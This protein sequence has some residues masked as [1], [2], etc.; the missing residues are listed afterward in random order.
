MVL[1]HAV[2]LALP[3]AVFVAAGTSRPL[4]QG[5]APAFRT[6]VDVVQLDVSVLDNNRQPIRGL[7]AADFT[8]TERGEARPIVSFEAI[9][10]P[11]TPAD[12][13]R[14]VT[15]V[16]PDVTVNHQVTRRVVVLFFDDFHTPFDPGVTRRAKTIGDAVLDRLGAADLAAVVYAVNRSNGQD[17][18]SDRALLREA[19]SR[20]L[21]TGMGVAPSTHAFSAAT[22]PTA[23]GVSGA[24][25]RASCVQKAMEQTARLLG[26]APG[27]RKTFLF[28]SSFTPLWSDD[29]ERVGDLSDWQGALRAMQEANMTVYQFDPRGLEVG[30]DISRDLG[31]FADATGGRTVKHTNTPEAAVPQMFRENQSYYLLGIPVEATER[32]TRFRPVSVSVNR[33]DATVRTRTG[34]FPPRV[35]QPPRSGRSAPEPLQ[36]ALT[37]ALPGGT[38]PVRLAVH[39]RPGGERRGTHA[40]EVLVGMAPVELR[41]EGEDVDVLVMAFRPDGSQ[42]ARV[43]HSVRITARAGGDEPPH[44][45]V[46]QQLD[47]A[48]GRYEIRAAARRKLTGETGSV[49]SS[50]T[51]PDFVREPI[52]MSGV[53]LV[54]MVREGDETRTSATTLRTFRP[55]DRVGVVLSVHQQSASAVNVDMN[56]R[57]VDERGQTRR[58]HHTT[59]E[60]AVFAP[61]GAAPVRFDVPIADLTPGEYLVVI[62]AASVRGTTSRSVRLHVK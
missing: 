9:E 41:D 43:A 26:A 54:R 3:I 24:C 37:A 15:E 33:P 58:T 56:L 42:V 18:T 2:A 49:Y 11:P 36:A 55:D 29:V 7:T 20:F 53:S 21:P 6:G 30:A 40:V 4:A 50:A 17:F 60:A 44:V 1:R 27:W 28:I 52:S 13:A 34:Y 46:S 25:I 8:V 38:L 5:Q 14:W 47:L 12:A 61:D 23:M 32:N 22:P 51:V 35:S 39:A 10:L 48:P 16:A 59:I 19:V 57:V 62:E 45:D 31:M